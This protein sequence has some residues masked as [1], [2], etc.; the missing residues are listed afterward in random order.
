MLLPCT[1]QWHLQTLF[2]R[3][4]LIAFG[5]YVSPLISLGSVSER[6]APVKEDVMGQSHGLVAKLLVSCR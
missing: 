1:T 6:V 2:R 4:F 3:G 5:R